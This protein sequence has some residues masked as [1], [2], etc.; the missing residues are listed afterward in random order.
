MPA[1]VEPTMVERYR[2]DPVGNSLAVLVLAGMMISVLAVARSRRPGRSGNRLGPVVPVLALVGIGVA[3][4]LTYVETS[5]AVAV[6]GPVGNC[7][8]VQQSEYARLFGLVPVGV[9][10]LVGYGAIIVAWLLTRAS[11]RTLATR[12]LLLLGAITV[13]GTLFS[14]YLTFLEPFIIGATCAWCLTSAVLITILMVLTVRAARTA[15]ATVRSGHRWAG[16]DTSEVVSGATVA[17]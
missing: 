1:A 12:A 8:A 14:M 7:N 16:L 15:W 9:V 17:P 13:A 4:Y 10:G 11:N 3:A 5:G 6:C 2:L